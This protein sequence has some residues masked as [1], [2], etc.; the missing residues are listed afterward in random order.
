MLLEVNS[1]RTA[2]GQPPIT[3][4]IAAQG[5]NDV[6]VSECPCFVIAGDSQGVT[7]KD[8][9]DQIKKVK[10]KPQSYHFFI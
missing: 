7:A 1:C 2:N 4:A 8:M 9:W 3:Y 6:H 5:T 10:K